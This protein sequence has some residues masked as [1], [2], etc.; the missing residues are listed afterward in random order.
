MCALVY[1]HIETSMRRR[2]GVVIENL[3]AE[4][5]GAERQRQSGGKNDCGSGEHV[6]FVFGQI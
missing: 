3:D 5:M 1:P 4:R 2:K 6:E